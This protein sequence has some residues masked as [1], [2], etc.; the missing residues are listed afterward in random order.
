MMQPTTLVSPL[1]TGSFGTVF[2]WRKTSGVAI[3]QVLDSSRRDELAHEFRTLK[4]IYH[5]C[6]MS[7]NMFKFPKPYNYYDSLDGLLAAI[8]EGSIASLTDVNKLG[9]RID[10]DACVYTM[11]RVKPIPPRL[12]SIIVDNYFPPTCKPSG[13]PG[14][15]SRLYLGCLEQK[16]SRYFSHV[17]FPLA[18]QTCMY[19]GIDTNA[20]AYSMGKLLSQLHF[21]ARMDA[22]DIEFVL[23]GSDDNELIDSGYYCIDFNQMQH[24]GNSVTQMIDAYDIN[25]PYYPRPPAYF[26][27][28]ASNKYNLRGTL[29]RLWEQFVGGYR[30]GVSEIKSMSSSD[31]LLADA[32]IEG[33]S[34]LQRPS[35]R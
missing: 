31:R 10:G 1:G 32:F 35:Q 34:V 4:T 28:S 30:C 27:L 18:L 6:D 7:N 2:T 8:A 5:D 15:I 17:N 19:I 12:S 29:Q 11:Q 26:D 9:Q 3:K 16:K 24:H 14:F 21:V 25:D 23:A 20:V 13:H 22:R 33:I